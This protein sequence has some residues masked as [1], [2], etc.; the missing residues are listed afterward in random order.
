[1]GL[2]LTSIAMVFIIICFINIFFKHVNKRFD[3]TKDRIYTLSA[4]SKK[5][6]SSLDDIVTIEFFITKKLPPYVIGMKQ[7]ITDIL[8]EYNAYGNGN[9]QI[10]INTLSP[11]T[12]THNRMAQLGIPKF[13]MNIIEKDKQQAVEAYS[14]IALFY[15]NKTEVIPLVL[16]INTLE[17]DLS[18]ALKKI[19]SNTIPNIG[20]LT[21][22]SETFKKSHQNIIKSL[23]KQYNVTILN[24]AES[25]TQNIQTLV[26][27]NPTNVS[28]NIKYNIDQF[29]MNGGNALF[30]VNPITISN[31]LETIKNNDTLTDLITH[32]GIK[33]DTSLVLDNSFSYAS[34]SE[35]YFSFM[36]PYPLWPKLIKQ[37]FNH[38]H[39]S[40]KSIESFVLPWSSPLSKTPTPSN[41][42]SITVLAKT[43]PKS[44]TKKLPVDLNPRQSFSSDL[45][46]QYDMIMSI[47][48]N[49][50]S[51]YTNKALGLS[52]HFN[53][54]SSESKI[55]VIGNSKFTSDQLTN[56]FPNNTT[57]YLNLVDWLTLENSL[58]EIPNRI[59]VDYPLKQLPYEITTLIKWVATLIIPI[60]I[61]ILGLLR[62]WIQKKPN[63]S[64]Q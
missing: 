14:G 18:L 51:F 32:Y 7:H 55:I 53:K 22:D 28:E 62:Y 26:L 29:I 27:H 1:M 45:L 25:I 48:G 49:L 54:T 4:Y 3:F 10:I 11:S 63:H 31:T 61:T 5:L 21:N 64:Y 24:Q 6:V 37:N 17:Y 36:L 16:N 35:G 2:H 12:Q 50:N 20:I 13:Q 23:K 42:S 41:K 9:I 56:Q 19:T 34:F 40:F 47:T 15:D 43:T 57:L 44:W 52:K 8:N 33:I 58:L 46:N 38:D 59:N 39:P 30:L 60:I